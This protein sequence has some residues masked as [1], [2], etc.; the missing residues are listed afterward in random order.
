MRHLRESRFVAVACM[1]AL[2]ACAPGLTPEEQDWQTI[3]ELGL[4][5]V[6]VE[7]FDKIQGYSTYEEVAAALPAPGVEL[8]SPDHVPARGLGNMDRLFKAAIEQPNST[9]YAWQNRDNE[10]MLAHFSNNQLAHTWDGEYIS[11]FTKT[12]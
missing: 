2:A 5:Y 11:M 3:N 9:V 6:T 8:T 10:I 1:G 7:E 4:E 12:E